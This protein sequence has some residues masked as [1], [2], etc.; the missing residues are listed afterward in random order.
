M[1]PDAIAALALVGLAAAYLLWRL[2]RL[3]RRARGGGGTDFVQ[4]TL[5][6]SEK[7]REERP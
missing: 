7:G 5:P 3:L 1:T 2:R 4:L 6:G